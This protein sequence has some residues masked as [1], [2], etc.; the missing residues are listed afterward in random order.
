MLRAAEQA[1]EINREAPAHGRKAVLYA[2]CFVN[3]NNPS[4]GLAA[5]AVLALIPDVDIEVIER[6]SGHGGSWGVMKD[7][8]NTALRTGKPV[9]RAAAKPGKLHIAS[10]CPLAAS[11]IIQG[12]ER[13]PDAEPATPSH[14][15][16][17][18]ARAYGLDTKDQP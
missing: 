6:C 14:P 18:F 4:I 12:M 5:R 13:L 7:N 11:H 15:I 1:P 16:E 10:E 3:Y 9:A 17:L 2:T 8:F